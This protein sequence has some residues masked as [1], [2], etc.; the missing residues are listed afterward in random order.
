MVSIRHFH[1]CSELRPQVKL[2]YALVQ[3][4]KLNKT[5]KLKKK[6]LIFKLLM[7]EFPITFITKLYTKIHNIPLSRAIN[8][9]K[10]FFK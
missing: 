4:N 10:N 3:K 6:T 7:V 8:I 9:K 1:C 2:L 5:K